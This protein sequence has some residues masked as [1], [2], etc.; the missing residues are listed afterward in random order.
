MLSSKDSFPINHKNLSHC[1]RL[2]YTVKDIILGNGLILNRSEKDQLIDIRNG[3]Y[4]Y[5]EIIELASNLEEE[6][7]KLFEE[8]KIGLPRE[9]NQ[10]QLQKLLLKIRKEH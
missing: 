1:V 9:V 5:E 2:L 8:N 6:V 10:K 3:K 7:K 4:S